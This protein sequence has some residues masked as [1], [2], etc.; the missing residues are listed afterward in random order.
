MKV[1]EVEAEFHRMISEVREEYRGRIF[2]LQTK[3]C[4]VNSA[5]EGVAVPAVSLPSN[6]TRG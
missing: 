2:D 1:S 3:F 6:E 4:R 5:T